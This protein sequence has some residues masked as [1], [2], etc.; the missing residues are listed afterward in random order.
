M[1]L[2]STPNKIRKL[3]F[4]LTFACSIRNTLIILIS[5]YDNNNCSVM[6]CSIISYLFLF[7]EEIFWNFLECSEMFWNFLEYSGIF[8]NV[9]E[10][11]FLSRLP[12]RMNRMCDQQ[13][14]DQTDISKRNCKQKNLLLKLK[15]KGLTAANLIFYNFTEY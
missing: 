13:N 8:W 3:F 9:L 12:N 2:I 10:L 7:Y 6:L 1:A 5:N 11:L 4:Q 15:K 14:L